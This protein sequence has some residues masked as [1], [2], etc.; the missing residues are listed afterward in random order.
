[1]SDLDGR[2]VAIAGAAGGLGPVVARDARRSRGDARPRRARLRAA[3]VRRHR[4]RAADRPHRRHH[5]STC[6]R[7][8]SAREL[9]RRDRR[10]LRQDRRAR[11]P[12]RRLARRQ[13]DRRGARRGRRV[14]P[15][16]AGQDACRLATRA[17]LPAPGGERRPLRDR[18]ERR[19]PSARAPTTPP[20]RRP[21]RRRGVDAR[22]RRRTRRARRNCEHHRREGDRHAADARREPGQGV[23]RRSRTPTRSRDAIAFLLSDAARK[24]NGQRALAARMTNRAQFASD[25]YA[26]APAGGAGRD[27]SASNAGWR[28]PTAAT[29]AP[30]RSQQRFRTHL[31]RRGARLPG[32][33]RDRRERR[34]AALR[35]ALARG[36]HLRRHRARERRRVRRARAR[37][38]L[39]AA[40]DRDAG[41]QA[42]ARARRPASWCASATSTP[43]SRA[44]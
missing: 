17:F 3:E 35:H 22:V 25:N 21:R 5:A 27:R 41:R 42:D 29:T 16:P 23:P 36:R 39:Q 19:R 37:R 7:S 4:P 10:A 1:M 20:T 28:R 2:V 24:M 31:R 15:R 13:A 43:C 11:A 14:P 32:L 30:R 44:S 34:L 26:P 33:Q 40:A 6:C 38:R 8:T 9:G 12:G 18:L